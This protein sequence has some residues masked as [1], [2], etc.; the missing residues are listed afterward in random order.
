ME[1]ETFKDLEITQQICGSFGKGENKSINVV[2][3]IWNQEQYFIVYKNKKDV[4]RAF[5]LQKALDYYN[6]INPYSGD[7]TVDK[8][9]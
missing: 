5:E 7:I 6:S 4:F 2:V 3:N 9:E 1:I 8:G